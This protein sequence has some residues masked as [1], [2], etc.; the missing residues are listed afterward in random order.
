MTLER[1]LR[2]TSLSTLKNHLRDPSLTL[3]HLL[4]SAG[5]SQEIKHLSHAGITS[6]VLFPPTPRDLSC[7]FSP[8][9][10]Y[11][12]PSVF[13]RLQFSRPFISCA[14]S[15]PCHVRSLRS[16]IEPTYTQSPDILAPLQPLCGAFE[17]PAH[18]DF[19]PAPQTTEPTR[20]S[21]PATTSAHLPAQYR[22]L[23]TR[24]LGQGQDLVHHLPWTT[25]ART[26]STL[27]PTTYID[28]CQSNDLIVRDRQ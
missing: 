26:R 18:P 3:F 6:H 21:P 12:T 9:S 28:Q 20:S 25:P 24:R 17:W 8:V 10:C 14:R 13:T 5:S 23:Q 2:L 16:R 19:D 15:Q 11:I 4:P 22:Q 27:R 1:P 7:G